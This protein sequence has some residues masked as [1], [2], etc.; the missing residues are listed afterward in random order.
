VQLFIF[1]SGNLA[2]NSMDIIIKNLCNWSHSTIR[3]DFH[4][5]ALPGAGVCSV[6]ISQRVLII[7]H[8]SGGRLQTKGE[9]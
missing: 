3:N 1:G 2:T 9:S 8:K 4:T 7:R 5:R 6:A